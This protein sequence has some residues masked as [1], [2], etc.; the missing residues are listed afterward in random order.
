MHRQG[1]T[2]KQVMCND[3]RQI[4]VVS[5]RHTSHEH[6]VRKAIYYIV[7]RTLRAVTQG[8]YL[9][10]HPLRALEAVEVSYCTIKLFYS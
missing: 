9:W 4:S 1:D 10:T 6:T 2:F 5:H 7:T 3:T 8:R